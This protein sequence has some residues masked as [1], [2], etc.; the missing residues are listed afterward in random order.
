[1]H[2]RCRVADNIEKFLTITGNQLALASSSIGLGEFLHSSRRIMQFVKVSWVK[3]EEHFQKALQLFKMLCQVFER[4]FLRTNFYISQSN[5]SATAGASI[6]LWGR[7]LSE[8]HI[9]QKSEPFWELDSGIICSTI[10]QSICMFFSFSREK[11]NR[12]REYFSINQ[13]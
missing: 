9:S 6:P 5:A 1:M 13:K 2:F 8:H 11:R 7:F 3:D 12:D 4:L 10:R